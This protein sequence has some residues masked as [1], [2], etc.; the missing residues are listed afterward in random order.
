MGNL[1]AWLTDDVG[2]PKNKGRSK[3]RPLPAD[4]R[5]RR[6]AA[7]T[8]Y[9]MLSIIMLLLTWYFISW[10][11]NKS[12]IPTPGQTWDALA[13]F[14]ENGD[15]TARGTVWDYI[16][17]SFGTLLKG[18]FLALLV[19]FPMSL[20]LGS[21][22]ILDKLFSPALNVLRPIAPVAWAPV[23]IILLQSDAMGAMMVVFIGCFFP[24]LT[25]MTFGVKKTDRNLYN[26]TKVLGA[27]WGQIFVKVTVPASIPYMMN[28][29]KTALGI[30]WM[31]IVSAELYASGVGGL[32]NYITNQA[33]LGAWPQVYAGIVIVGLLG[34]LTVLL[35]DYVSRLLNRRWGVEE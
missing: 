28:G 11:V 7:N 32:G 21:V 27:S 20:F 25:T 1:K 6:L 2:E 9:V 19:A 5:A 30:G 14:V 13:D 22:P 10:Y 3:N 15:S 34:L 4:D 35:A 29:V 8:G 26:A 23:M 31:C 18:F 33:G 16:S 24:I 17:A 12:V